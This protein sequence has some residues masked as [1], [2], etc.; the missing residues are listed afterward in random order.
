[1]SWLKNIFSGGVADLAETAAEIFTT[2]DKERLEQ[3]RAET[4]R[5]EVEQ[6]SQLMQQK[7]NLAQARHRSLFVAGPRPFIM[8][9]GGLALALHFFLYPLIQLFVPLFVPDIVIPDLPT[10]MGL[11]ITILGP[12]LGIGQIYR[13]FEK[14][15]G[16]SQ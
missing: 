3:Y 2:T 6:E 12:L 1:M 4:E 11:L 15:K 10:E 8:W 7:V 13:T 16:L 5:M 14:T 9:V